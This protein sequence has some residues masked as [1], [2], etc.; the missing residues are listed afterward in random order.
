[1]IVNDNQEEKPM[2]EKL[3][4]HQKFSTVINKSAFDSDLLL[5]TKTCTRTRHNQKT[6]LNSIGSE[7]TCTNLYLH[8]HMNLHLSTI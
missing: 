6:L 3:L 7:D 5:P 1:M 8:Y 4:M 2:S